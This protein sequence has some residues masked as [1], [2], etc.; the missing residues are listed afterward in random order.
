MWYNL[1]CG[2]KKKGVYR[3]EEVLVIR[4][5]FIKDILKGS[6]G[7]GIFFKNRSEIEENPD[8]VQIIP[9]V[10]LRN[11]RRYALITVGT[12]KDPRIKEPLSLLISGHINHNDEVTFKNRLQFNLTMVG[13][14]LREL[15]EEICW[16]GPINLISL[17]DPI[18]IEEGGCH[19]DKY[20]VGI[21]FILDIPSRE[22]CYPNK[23]VA[24]INFKKL[25]ELGPIA[26]KLDSWS[27]EVLRR[28]EG[29]IS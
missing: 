11:N 5:E 2:K 1:K 27:L 9:C 29:G 12:T 13:G 14:L 28:L 21:P 4:K 10:V 18:Y 19:A 26:G 20:H 24:D 3:M 25:K 8:Y 23:E 22:L 17:G 6:P 15:S 16:V 7:G